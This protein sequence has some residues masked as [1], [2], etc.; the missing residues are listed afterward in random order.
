MARFDE[1]IGL[2]RLK[3]IHLNDSKGGLNSRLDRHE[4]IGMGYIREDGFNV[5]LHHD[6]IRKLPMILETPVDDRR[7]DVGNIRMVRMLAEG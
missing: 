7:D 3:L 5:I 2:D 1:A 4:H 6:A